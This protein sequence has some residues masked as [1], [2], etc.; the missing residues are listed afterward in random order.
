MSNTNHLY[1]T[2][3]PNCSLIGSQY[4]PEEF[5]VH[6]MSGSTRHYNGKVI[7]AEIDLDYRH[8]YFD[9]GRGIEGLVPHEDGRPKATKFISTY[10]VLEHIDF[11]A[12]KRLY[13]TTPS[14][15][16]LGLDTAPYDVKHSPGFIRLFAEVTP[17]RMLVLSPLSFP[18]FGA[19]ITDSRNP[20][21]APKLFYTQIELDIDVFMA[22]F[23]RNPFLQTP[24]PSVHP[25]KLRD[26]VLEIRELENK[27]TKGLSLDSNLNMMSYRDVRHG[28]MFASHEE[29]KFFRMP[30]VDEIEDTNYRFARE[31]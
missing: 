17:M 4:S 7:F 16:V 22:E 24:I 28:F 26:A 27:K 9:I 13:L 25:S 10:R 1:M 11:N 15:I 18:E 30:S 19:A 8:E 6:Y 21:G 14:A 3:H 2:L 31:M 5:A 29:Y 20:K 12:I 23:E